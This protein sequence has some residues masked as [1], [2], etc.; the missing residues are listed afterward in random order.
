[1]PCDGL[2]AKSKSRISV[3]ETTERSL[4]ERRML[5]Y[6]MVD[7]VAVICEAIIA[8][9]G[10]VVQPIGADAPEITARFA[11]PAGNVIGLC[12]QPSGES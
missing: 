8:E 6:I 3:E 1:M 12:Q 4:C 9:G 5:I 11:D 7:R 2:F 10:K